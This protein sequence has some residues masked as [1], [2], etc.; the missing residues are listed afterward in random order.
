MIDRLRRGQRG[1]TLIELLV[2]VAIIALL[3]G[4]LLPA[5]SGARRSAWQSK[6][7]ALQQ[8]MLRGILTYASQNKDYI[9]GMNTSGRRN[10]QIINGTLPTTLL[11]SQADL[12]TQSWDWMTPSLDADDLNINRAARYV[13]IMSKFADPA[14]REVITSAQL[15]A[16]DGYLGALQAEVD[17]KGGVTAPSF[18]MPAY[19]QWAGRTVGTGITALQYGPPSNVTNEVTI[20]TGYLPRLDQIQLSAKKIGVCDGYVDIV[21]PAATFDVSLWVPETQENPLGTFGVRSPCFPDSKA[22]SASGDRKL[23]IR[24]GKNMNA[25]YWDGHVDVLAERDME[26]PILWYPSGS[27]LGTTVTTRANEYVQTLD[28]QGQRRVP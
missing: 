17:K 4:V 14:N 2:V 28:S 12:P 7:A 26:N 5:L 24:H 13:Q 3:I 1:F 11:E 21:D 22:Y 19:W 8:Q 25:G 6:G 18:F 23:S 27:V 15:S 16:S 9:P 10:Q 20:P